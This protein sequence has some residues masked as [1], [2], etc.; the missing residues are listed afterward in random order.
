MAT[1]PV[2]PFVSVV[3]PVIAP[4]TAPVIAGAS[5]AAALLADLCD[6]PV[7]RAAVLYLDPK[8][9]LLGR[10]DFTGTA[11]AVAPTFRAIFAEALRLDATALVLAHSHPGGSSTASA[12]D[13]AF[14]RALVRTGAALDV[15]VTDHLI[16][17]RDG[18]T[19][20]REAGLL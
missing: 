17:A 8:W 15:T 11:A 2:P 13:I 14:T 6:S 5:D 7:E 10:V 20:L 18:T 16:V 4:V 9:R 19:S 1:A 12:Q 3:A